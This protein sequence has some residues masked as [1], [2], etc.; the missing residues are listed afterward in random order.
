MTLFKPTNSTNAFLLY[1]GF[2]ALLFG[3]KLWTIHSYGNVTPFWDQWDAEASGLY[4]PYL[5]GTLGWKNLIAPHNE[6]RIF[7]TRILALYLLYT[8]NIWNPLLQ[9]VVNA[10]LHTITIVLFA[11]LLVRVIGYSYLPAL[12]AFSL[13]LFAI[14]YGWENILVGFQSQFY[15]V[16]LFSIASI[17]LLTTKEPFSIKWFLGLGSGILAF[18]SLASGVFTFAAAAC[19]AFIFYVFKIRRTGKELLAI[20][21]LSGLFIIGFLLTPTLKHQAVYKA[22]SLREFV[23]ALMIVFGWPMPDNFISPLIRNLPIAIFILVM[24]RER[25]PAS[26]RRWFI[27]AL[28]VWCVSQ[29]IGMAYGRANG[30]LASRYKDLYVIPVFMNFVC[31]LSLSKI[32]LTK[33]RYYG[34]FAIGGWLVIVLISLGSFSVKT[35][36][37]ELKWKR[38]IGR[39]EEINTR[40]YILTG[41]INNLKDKPPME[42]PLPDPERLALTIEMPGIRDILPA[43]INRPLNTISVEKNSNVFAVNCYINHQK[44]YDSTWS[45][46]CANSTAMM[47]QAS[48]RFHSDKKFAKIE[49]PIAGFPL[50]KGIRLEMVQNGE[51]TPIPIDRDPGES[52]G[53]AYSII[54]NNDFSINLSDSS[55]SVKG[56]IAIGAP[57][58]RGRFDN[59]ITEVLSHYYLF[60]LLGIVIVTILLINVGLNNLKKVQKTSSA[61]NAAIPT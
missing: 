43:D 32:D 52:W 45:S 15:F 9:M 1:A 11:K 37:D 35:L 46:H 14:P 60:I 50:A 38:E 48:L 51:R 23:Y 49:I 8:N 34:G 3:I 18:L 10:A 55:T 29:A 33:Y 28:C 27:F 36:P 2:F 4:R 22:H 61:Q 39:A 56:W 57:I 59:T 31:L 42:V 41:D 58:V 20:V 24:L 47:G 16:V 12:L 26:D 13:V 40:N 25:P 6:H 30:I 17:W 53:A 21:I 44:D 5:D 7:T 19:M 54:S